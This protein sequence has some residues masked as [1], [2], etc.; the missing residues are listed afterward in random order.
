[1]CGYRYFLAWDGVSGVKWNSY[2]CLDRSIIGVTKKF[3]RGG[4]LKGRESSSAEGASNLG[5][6]MDIFS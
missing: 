5:G 6:S 3:L 1:M 2:L 4:R